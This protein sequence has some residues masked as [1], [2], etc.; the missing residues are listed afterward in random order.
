MTHNVLNAQAQNI[1]MNVLPHTIFLTMVVVKL[2]PI[3]MEHYVLHVQQVVY[4][5]LDPLVK[6]V[7]VAMPDTNLQLVVN[8]LQI[9]K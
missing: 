5:V 2:Q 9:P 4:L 8:V 1:V 3:T 7:L 6:N